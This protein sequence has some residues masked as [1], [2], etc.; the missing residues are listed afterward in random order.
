MFL[1]IIAI[2]LTIAVITM[3]SLP[4]DLQVPTFNIWD[5]T[6]HA[7]GYAVISFTAFLGFLTPRITPLK[8]SLFYTFLGIALECAQYFIPGRYFEA[9]D[10]V[11]NFIGVAIGWATYSLFRRLLPTNKI[12]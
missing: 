10:M 7:F 12:V 4:A 9:A 1:K 11:A 5:K 6:L 3:S 2:S 8:I